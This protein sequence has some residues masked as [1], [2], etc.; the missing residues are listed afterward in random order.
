MSRLAGRF[1]PASLLFGTP[2]SRN[3]CFSTLV[4]FRAFLSLVLTRNA[5]CRAAVASVQAWCAARGRTVPGESTSAYCQARLRL[6]LETVRSIFSAINAWIERRNEGASALLNGRRVRVVDGTG[7]SM[8]D[9]PDNR[10]KWPLAGNQKTGCGFPV[11]QFAGLFCLHTGRLIKFAFE[12]WKQ[13]EVMLARQ[14]A[15]WVHQ[16]EVLLADR[17]FCS[18][19]LIALFRRKGVDVV[20][21]LHHLRKDRPGM[22]VWKKPQ[23]T[24]AWGKCLWREP[25][26]EL[27]MRIVIFAVNVRGFRTRRITLCTTLPD[28]KACPDEALAALYLRRWRIELFFRDIKVS[29]GLDVVRCQTP[30][31]L[32]KEIWMQA[33]ACNMV[34]ALMLE[35]AMTHGASLERLSFKGVVDKLRAWA[36]WMNARSP[37]WCKKQLRELL[38]AIASDQMPL[39]PH[40]SEPRAVKRRPKSYQL[41]TRPRHEMVVSR[42]RRDK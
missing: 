38:R 40:R 19:G 12:G 31:M 28:T 33:I 35:A 30:A 2:K 3:R 32:E 29:P 15:G 25:P 21:R 7:A 27:R 37:A 6:P 36:G 42:S 18:R 11:I 22:S 16:G 39:R 8:P 5:S 17:G 4:V 1:F 13:R 26:R 9:T 34:R 41:L 14:L 24:G 20:M 10:K 23:R